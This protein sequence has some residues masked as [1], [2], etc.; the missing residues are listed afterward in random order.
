MRKSTRKSPRRRCRRRRRMT[1]AAEPDDPDTTRPIP[2]KVEEAS[3]IFPS[4]SNDAILAALL[5]LLIKDMESIQEVNDAIGAYEEEH[6]GEKIQKLAMTSPKLQEILTD[7][8]T[9]EEQNNI[10]KNESKMRNRI[11]SLADDNPEN[12]SVVKADTSDGKSFHV[13]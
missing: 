12:H 10:K 2:K 11:F 6:H 5:I 1:A 9:V 7:L 13:L 3:T 8:S 4:Y